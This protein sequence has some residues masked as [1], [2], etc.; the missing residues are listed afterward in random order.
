M[1]VSSSPPL[2]HQTWPPPDALLQVFEWMDVKALGDVTSVSKMW[3]Y[4]AER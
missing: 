3:K 4:T 1:S 2:P